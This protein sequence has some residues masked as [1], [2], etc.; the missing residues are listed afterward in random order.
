MDLRGGI[1]FTVLIFFI[2]SCGSDSEDADMGIDVFSF[3]FSFAQS[4][5]EWYGNFADYKVADF[6]ES[7]LYFSHQNLPSSLANNQKSLMISGINNDQNLFMFIKRKITG[8]SPNKDYTLVF[9]LNFISST[10]GNPEEG[11]S[12]RIKVGAVPIEPQSYKQ[13][14]YYRMNIDKGMEGLSGDDMVTIGAIPINDSQDKY[15]TCEKSNSSSVSYPTFTARSDS[16]GE[17]WLVIGTNS[18]FQGITTIYYTNV[19]VVF[20]ASN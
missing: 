13:N 11:D 1:F 6:E 2:S 12:V 19:K 7:E 16:R 8:L 9:K 10:K 4:Q 17:L 5:H 14:E 20:S 3:S 18:S 15:D